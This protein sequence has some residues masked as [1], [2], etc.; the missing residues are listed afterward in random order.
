MCR[1]QAHEELGALGLAVADYHRSLGAMGVRRTMICNTAY[2]LA[3]CVAENAISD[4][5]DAALGALD[6]NPALRDGQ[7]LSAG[8]HFADLGARALIAAAR[9]QVGASALAEQAFTVLGFEPKQAASVA[10][11]SRRSA[12]MIRRVAA[13]LDPAHPIALAVGQ[14]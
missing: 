2:F 1:A 9:G 3:R 13:V 11:M 4:A 7:H 10:T 6:A 5:F 12:G 8:N 14:A